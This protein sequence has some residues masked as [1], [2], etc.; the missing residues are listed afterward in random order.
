MYASFKRETANFAVVYAKSCKLLVSH[1]LK[2]GLDKPG[3]PVVCDQNI[4]MFIVFQFI[5]Q[6]ID[7]LGNTD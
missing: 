4:G 7:T 6:I 2:I 5:Q 1:V 3:D